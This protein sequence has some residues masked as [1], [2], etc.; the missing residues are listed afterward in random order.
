[1]TAKK[2]LKQNS[3]SPNDRSSTNSDDGYFCSE[4]VAKAF[5][6]SKL[7][8]SNKACSSFW[9]IDFAQE[10]RLKLKGATL[11]REVTVVLNKH[12]MKN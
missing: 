5:K 4:L 1:M 12:C 6:V 10:K 9:P 8:D 11:E 3:L 2:L 7:L